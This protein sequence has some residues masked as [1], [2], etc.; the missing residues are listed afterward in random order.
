MGRVETRM[1]S[2]DGHKKFD[3]LPGIQGVKEDSRNID[4]HV[5]G[6][7]G[8]QSQESV[9]TIKAAK[10]AGLLSKLKH[11]HARIITRR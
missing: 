8:A 3:G 11:P 9:L 2:V 6:C 1:F 4:I 5:S 10:K 7:F